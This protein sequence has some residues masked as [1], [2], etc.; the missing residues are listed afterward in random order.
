VRP[1]RRK[2]RKPPALQTRHL[3]LLLEMP[4]IVYDRG[5][6]FDDAL[7]T[8]TEARLMELERGGF[9]ALSR[10]KPSML[11]VLLTQRG[12]QLLEGLWDYNDRRARRKGYRNRRMNA[13]GAEEEFFLPR[14]GVIIQRLG[15]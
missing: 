10:P 11:D 2:Q 1:T 7:G 13:N 4:T 8:A 3:A 6:E 14:P 12:R 5:G 15:L 9:I